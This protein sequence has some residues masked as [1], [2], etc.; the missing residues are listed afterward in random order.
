MTE[1]FNPEA[2]PTVTPFTEMKQRAEQAEAALAQ[3][4]KLLLDYLSE[5]PEHDQADIRVFDACEVLSG[6][7]D[8]TVG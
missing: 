6:S 5:F 7:T 8:E 3:A 2:E 1:D 4:R